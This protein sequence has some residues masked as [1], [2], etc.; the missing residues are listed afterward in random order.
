MSFISSIRH[1]NRFDLSHDTLSPC[2]F[3]SLLHSVIMSSA[4]KSKTSSQTDGKATQSKKTEMGM[5]NYKVGG[6][7][8]C[9]NSLR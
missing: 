5:M 1:Q 7:L 6:C 9:Q 3:S 2:F 8:L 4:D